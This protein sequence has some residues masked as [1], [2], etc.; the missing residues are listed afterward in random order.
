MTKEYK[1]KVVENNLELM[2]G[3]TINLITDSY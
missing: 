1:R 2:N 3:S